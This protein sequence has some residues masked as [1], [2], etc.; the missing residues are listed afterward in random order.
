MDLSSEIGIQNFRRSLHLAFKD[1]SSKLDVRQFVKRDGSID[2]QAAIMSIVDK[3]GFNTLQIMRT[4]RTDDKPKVQSKIPAP[5]TS[6]TK[7]MN[8][9]F[10]CGNIKQILDDETD[11]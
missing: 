6:T 4:S 11:E 2:I 5:S 3:V 1:V 10:G 7:K 9:S 8:E